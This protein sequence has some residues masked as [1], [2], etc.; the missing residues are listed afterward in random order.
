MRLALCYK[1]MKY[2]F[3]VPDGAADYPCE[4]LGGKTPLEAADKPFMDALA[5][6]GLLGRVKT[7]PSGFIPSSDVANLS[8]LGYEPQKYYCGRGP[9]EAANMGVTLGEDDLAFRC[10]LITEAEGKLLDYSAGHISDHEAKI[11]IE[12]INNNL[13]TQEIEFYPGKSYRHLMVYRNGKKL[14]LEK[15]N[16]VAPH[17]IMGQAIAK[18]LPKGKGGEAVITLMRRSQDYLREHEINKVRIDL[19]ENQANMIWLWGEI[20]RAS[21][22]ERV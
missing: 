8:L 6:K 1:A 4:L 21:C 20:G 16:Y 3:I 14:G 17:D 22:R 11:L 15:L 9:L 12:N 2:I 18:H 10:N 7:V 5:Q 13:G 19:G